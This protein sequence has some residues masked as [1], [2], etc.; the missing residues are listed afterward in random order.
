MELDID[1]RRSELEADYRQLDE[2]KRNLEAQVQE[3][4]VKLV[5]CEGAWEYLSTLTEA[6][7]EDASGTDDTE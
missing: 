5:K 7:E 4:S 1:K 3:V 6:E 2:Q